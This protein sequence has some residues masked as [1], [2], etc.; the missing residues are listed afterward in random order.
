MESQ[1]TLCQRFQSLK[2]FI[3]T[4]LRS[5]LAAYFGETEHM[6]NKIDFLTF[7]IKNN[8]KSN[9]FNIVVQSTLITKVAND[10]RDM[11]VYTKSV[12]IFVNNF[13]DNF[14]LNNECVA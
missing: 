10:G 1:L 12:I 8:L 3:D 4:E 2:N 6:I 9:D 11:N 7:Y 5:I 13:S 14:Q